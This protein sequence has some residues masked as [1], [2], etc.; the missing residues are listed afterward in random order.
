MAQQETGDPWSIAP[1]FTEKYRRVRADRLKRYH[2]K[3]ILRSLDEKNHVKNASFRLDIIYVVCFMCCI[4]FCS[5]KKFVVGSVSSKIDKFWSATAARVPRSLEEVCFL[6][7]FNG[8]LLNRHRFI[9][10]TIAVMG[11]CA[12]FIYSPTDSA[13]EQ[14][15]QVT[16]ATSD[17]SVYAFLEAHCDHMPEGHY[18][19]AHFSF[20]TI[21]LLIS[22]YCVAS[23][24]FVLGVAFTRCC[25]KPSAQK[26]VYFA[27]NHPHN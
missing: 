8:Y 11:A 2:E 5:K 15:L 26:G 16:N 4:P 21:W 24:A 7:S 23:T 20:W 25:S 1:S 9:L 17:G 19:G 14:H 22:L 18:D 27:E 13:H 3:G 12:V 10:T 6:L